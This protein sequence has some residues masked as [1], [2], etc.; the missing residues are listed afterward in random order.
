MTTRKESRES[1]CGGLGSH[2]QSLRS[3]V[4]FVR[5]RRR[6]ERHHGDGAI[7]TGMIAFVHLLSDRRAAPRRVPGK[8]ETQGGFGWSQAASSATSRDDRSLGHLPLI[9]PDDDQIECDTLRVTEDVGP[10]SAIAESRR[11]RDEGT[12]NDLNNLKENARLVH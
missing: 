7:P 6:R 12:Y 3:T 8:A 11:C 9:N 10:S 4:C 5:S 2:R 1:R